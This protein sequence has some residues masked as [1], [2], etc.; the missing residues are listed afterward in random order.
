MY[1]YRRLHDA[2]QN[3]WVTTP[4]CVSHQAIT[5]FDTRQLLNDIRY[6]YDRTFGTSDKLISVHYHHPQQKQ[7]ALR[8]CGAEKPIAKARPRCLVPFYKREDRSLSHLFERRVGAQPDLLDEV[9]QAAG[10]VGALHAPECL[11]EHLLHAHDGAVS[12]THSSVPSFHP[13]SHPLPQSL[14]CLFPVLP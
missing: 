6:W 5:S 14:S 10:L 2:T 13:P 1:R 4:C 11:R 8:C 12:P 9:V 3:K 7:E